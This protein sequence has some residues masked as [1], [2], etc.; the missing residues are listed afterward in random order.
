M[1]A[2]NLLLLRCTM[3]RGKTV[4]SLRFAVPC[5]RSKELEAAIRTVK[6]I[7]WRWSLL[8]IEIRKRTGIESCGVQAQG[9][10]LRRS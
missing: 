7:L 5:Q 8:L 6:T 3:R 10:K 9:K 1:M 2:E 4:E